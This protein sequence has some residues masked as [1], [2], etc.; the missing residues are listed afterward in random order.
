MLAELRRRN[1]PVLLMG[2]RAPP[3]LGAD[4]VSRF[5]A[6]YPELAQEYDA[7]LVPF[8]LESI[9]TKP[10]LIQRDRVHPTAQGI[11]TLV[12][13]TVNN[14]VAALPEETEAVAAR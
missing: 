5:D 10:Q 14:V 11:E 12:G 6:I 4:F 2:M 3:N 8:F 13:A 9:Y 7:D 1:I